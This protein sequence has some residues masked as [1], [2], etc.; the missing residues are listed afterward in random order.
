MRAS[1]ESRGTRAGAPRL[2]RTALPYVSLE[3]KSIDQTKCHT[4]F[5]TMPCEQFEQRSSSALPCDRH[6]C[7]PVSIRK[8]TPP[9]RSAGVPLRFSASAAEFVTLTP[10]GAAPNPALPWAAT[11]EKASPAAPVSGDSQILKESTSCR[12]IYAV[13]D[14]H[15][16]PALDACVPA[17]MYLTK[18]AITRQK[19][20]HTI[21]TVCRARP[22]SPCANR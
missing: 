11:G 4:A 7:S 1:H 17:P 5:W 20:L 13:S 16:Q 2:R 12:H 22:I 19:T 18:P 3:S 8:K 10:W 21:S 9:D 14:R 6:V 15:P